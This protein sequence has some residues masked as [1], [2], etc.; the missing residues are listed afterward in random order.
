MNVLNRIIMVLIILFLVVA[1]GTVL[2]TPFNSVSV[3]RLNLDYMETILSDAQVL[4]IFR[5]A[6]AGVLLILLLLLWFELWRPRRKTVRIK[7]QSGGNAQLDVQSVAQSLEYRI[8]E[9]PGVR[10]VRPRIISRGRDV[11]VVLDLDTSPSVNIPALTEQIVKLT[12]DIV[13]GQLGLKIRSKVRLNIR[14]EPY[15]RG[16]MPSTGPLGKE[17]VVPPVIERPATPKAAEPV[18]APVSEPAP[19]T[20]ATPAEAGTA[21]QEEAKQEK[22]ATSD[23]QL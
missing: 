20:T 21:S 5:A 18:I 17:S 6:G 15:P 4:M 23:N 1:V 14:H 9:L 2:L 3:T 7:T 22:G 11:E 8:D 13:E 16:T 19:T 12:N 10:Q